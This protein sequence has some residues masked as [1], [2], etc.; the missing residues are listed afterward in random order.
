MSSYAVVFRDG[1]VVLVRL[2]LN[3]QR[4]PHPV[5][6]TSPLICGHSCPADKL[7]LTISTKSMEATL[8]ILPTEIICQIL[9]YLSGAEL[10]AASQTCRVINSVSQI[11]SLWEALC[12]P[13]PSHSPYRSWY[14]LYSTLWYRYGW[15]CGVWVSDV[16]EQA[17][18][19]VKRYNPKTGLIDYHVRLPFSSS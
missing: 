7:R 1:H 10:S 11:D 3:P 4:K 15:L 16:S 19:T 5:H 9:S 6:V 2:C 18:M 17:E 12:L 13:L 8:T 14:E